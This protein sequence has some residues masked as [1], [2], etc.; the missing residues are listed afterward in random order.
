[1]VILSCMQT[2]LKFYIPLTKSG[3]SFEIEA[4][5]KEDC[6]FR[7]PV[8]LSLLLLLERGFGIGYL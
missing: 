8:G 5:D 6:A 7:D 2:A 1:M 4:P 3:S